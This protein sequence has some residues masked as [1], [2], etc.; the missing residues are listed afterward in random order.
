ME[1]TPIVGKRRQD[2]PCQLF[3]DKEYYL[4]KGERYFSRGRHRLH[5]VVWEHFNGA[6][7]KGY[8][9]HHKDGNTHNNTIANLELVESSTHLSKHV[10][11][12]MQDEEYSRR[13]RENMHKAMECAKKWHASEEGREWHREHG[14]QVAANLQ[15][16]KRVCEWCGKEYETKTVGKNRFCSNNCRTRYRYHNGVDNE[17]R[18]CPVCGKHFIANKYT[19]SH[20]CCSKQCG[21][22]ARFLGIVLHPERESSK[23]AK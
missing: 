1:A 4:Y 18:I 12:N 10:R 19:K 7:P 23:Q 14:K 5:I 13:A 20:V 16:I 15:P 3:N 21:G 6:I 11:A 17:E 9:V 2:L 22:K 8:H